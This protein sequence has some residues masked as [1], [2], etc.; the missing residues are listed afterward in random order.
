MCPFKQPIPH[1]NPL[2]FLY[3][4]ICSHLN[5]NSFILVF[6]SIYKINFKSRRKKESPQAT[7]ELKTRIKYL[8][9][10]Q[11]GTSIIVIFVVPGY[12]T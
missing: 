1:L 6:T 2:L 5:F 12:T 3:T 7:N 9:F 4:F 10:R 11:Q 8:T